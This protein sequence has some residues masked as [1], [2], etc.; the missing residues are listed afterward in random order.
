M[1]TLYLFR[2]AKSSWGFDLPDHDRPLGKRGRGD[3][4]KMGEFLKKNITPPEVII[5][6]TAS[7]AFY[8]ALHICDCLGI[9]E[10]KILLTKELFHAG[11]SEILHVVQNTPDCETLAIFGHNPGFTV[12]AN[13]LSNSSIENVPTG[14]V[15]GIS[16]DVRSWSKVDFGKG[17]KTFFYYPKGI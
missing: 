1:K 3:V 12:S 15:V 14:G 11:S 4:L 9:K 2:H 16:F 8:T 6:S 13:R 10:E 5:S 7:R 17:K